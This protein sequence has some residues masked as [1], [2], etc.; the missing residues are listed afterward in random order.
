MTDWEVGRGKE[1]EEEGQQ[2]GKLKKEN[3]LRIGK[4]SLKK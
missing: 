1:V 4:R 2:N 3:I